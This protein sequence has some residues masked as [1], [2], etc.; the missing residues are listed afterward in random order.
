M[1]EA[2]VLIEIYFTE[3]T[4]LTRRLDKVAPEI[5]AVAPIRHEKVGRNDNFFDLGGH[6]LLAMQVAY[7][8]EQ[9]IGRRVP[10]MDLLLQTLTQFAAAAEAASR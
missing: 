8:V 7:R 9:E 6:S 3:A 2:P 1:T 10:P 4:A 5:A